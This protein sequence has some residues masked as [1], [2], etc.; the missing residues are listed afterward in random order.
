VNM[1]CHRKPKSASTRSVYR[2]LNGQTKD[3][4]Y[5]TNGRIIETCSGA[6]GHRS[7][8]PFVISSAQSHAP[9]SAARSRLPDRARST[10]SAVSHPSVHLVSLDFVPHSASAHLIWSP[11]RFSA[12]LSVHARLF[13]VW[14]SAPLSRDMR[15]HVIR[16]GHRCYAI[17]AP[18]LRDLRTGSTA[19]LC[20]F[21][22][23]TGPCGFL[24]VSPLLQRCHLRLRVMRSPSCRSLCSPSE[25]CSV[26][27]NATESGT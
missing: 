9:A 27:L 24:L 4:S 22:V 3:N 26:V 20:C 1:C 25:K 15:I 18:M 2:R 12:S 11:A 7:Q 14:F 6:N 5:Q 21:H 17:C 10:L 8:I 13:L 16:S 23:V 19:P